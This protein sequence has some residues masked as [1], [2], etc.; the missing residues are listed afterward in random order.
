MNVASRVREG[1]TRAIS[2]IIT[3]LL[4]YTTTF[5]DSVMFVRGRGQEL[6]LDMKEIRFM[7]VV[8]IFLEVTY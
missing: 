3:K 6:W 7:Q 1:V 2:V 5:T 4:H 8:T